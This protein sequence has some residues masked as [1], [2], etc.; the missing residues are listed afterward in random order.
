[1][2]NI[3]LAGFV[4]ALVLCGFEAYARPCEKCHGVCCVSEDGFTRDERVSSPKFE[5]SQLLGGAA[6]NGHWGRCSEEELISGFKDRKECKGHP[7]DG[8][9]CYESCVLEVNEN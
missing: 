1:M 8:R 2:R 5:F 9:I 7:L 3:V 6:I 4:S